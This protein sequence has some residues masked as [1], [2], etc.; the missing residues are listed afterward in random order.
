MA[1]SRVIMKSC[2]IVGLATVIGAEWTSSP[3]ASSTWY[4]RN[5]GNTP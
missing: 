4:V 5:G 3:A 1:W 2:I